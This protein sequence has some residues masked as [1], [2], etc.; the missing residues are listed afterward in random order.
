MH[1]HHSIEEKTGKLYGKAFELLSHREFERYLE[2]VSAKVLEEPRD[3]FNEKRILILGCGGLGHEIKGFLCQGASEVVGIDISKENIDKLKVRFQLNRN[4]RLINSDIN[5]LKKL[6][7]GPFN[8]VFSNGVIHHM[9]SPQQ[10]VRDAYSLLKPDGKIVVGL[11]GKGGVFPFVISAVRLL[12]FVIPQKIV[13]TISL[14]LRQPKFFYVMDYL[15]VPIL[16]RYTEKKATRLLQEAGFDNIKRLIYP[17]YEKSLMRF[18]MQS[19][20]DHTR[21]FWR[22]LH[23]HG[24]IYLKGMKVRRGGA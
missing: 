22:I 6:Q 20:S 7:L 23:G 14:F 2:V 12:R 24:W 3:Y 19:Q 18:C 21:T 16:H 5:E 4:V 17:K 13:F 9:R 10:V 8:F 1:N 11:F 15:Y